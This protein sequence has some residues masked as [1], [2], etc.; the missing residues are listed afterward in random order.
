MNYVRTACVSPMVHIGNI[1]KN[2][3]EI[4]NSYMEFRN[5]CDILV[6]PELSI[7][8][9]TCG[10]LFGNRMLIEKAEE[11]LLFLKN[12]TKE[13]PG[14]CLAVGL[15]LE[16]KNELYNCAALMCGG[17]ILGIVP[18]VYLPNYS[19]FYEKRWFSAGI[20][21]KEYNGGARENCM[22]EAKK[23]VYVETSV[24][25]YLT[26]KPSHDLIKNARQ[27]ATQDWWQVAP[28]DLDLW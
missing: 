5:Q 23:K 19:E 3:E 8:G 24:V 22:A 25:S 2:C 11:G 17:E 6:T 14:A 15:P 21:E 9:Y 20:I 18:K 10:D 1:E 28:N 27:L 26:A 7:T 13:N 12:L 4:A 16:Y